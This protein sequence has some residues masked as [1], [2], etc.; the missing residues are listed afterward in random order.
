MCVISSEGLSSMIVLSMIDNW[1]FA[2]LQYLEKEGTREE[3]RSSARGALWVISG[4]NMMMKDVT[5]GRQ[6]RQHVFFNTILGISQE[7]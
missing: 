6:S 2:A 5:P 3:I 7:V 4:R 1:S